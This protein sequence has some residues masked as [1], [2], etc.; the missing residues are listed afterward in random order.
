M[1]IYKFIVEHENFT[2]KKPFGNLLIA[3]V[4]GYVW[5][6]SMKALAAKKNMHDKKFTWWKFALTTSLGILLLTIVIKLILMEPIPYHILFLS[7]SVA[8][9]TAS[10][11]GFIFQFTIFKNHKKTD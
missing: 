3:L 6:E 7:I 5:S 8:F 4:I 9:G 2:W 1:M 10:V 11:F